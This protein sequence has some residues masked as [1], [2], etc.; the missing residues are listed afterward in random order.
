MQF[1][2]E[3]LSSKQHFYV[4]MVAGGRECFRKEHRVGEKCTQK[5]CSQ[6]LKFLSVE[7]GE[8]MDL[9]REE[10]PIRMGGEMRGS[11]MGGMW[12]GW[13]GPALQRQPLFWATPK[14]EQSPKKGVLQC[15]SPASCGRAG[16]HARTQPGSAPPLSGLASHT[17]T[18][19]VGA[20]FFII[21]SATFF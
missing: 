21:I 11:P 15:G 14:R 12:Q 6:P 3:N 1:L 8:R 7:R 18:C 17:T 2:C 16:Q 9:G 13:A 20:L 5:K 10:G 4:E 19:Q